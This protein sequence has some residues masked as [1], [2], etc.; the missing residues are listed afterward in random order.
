MRSF[1]LQNRG[2]KQDFGLQPPSPLFIPPI[3]AVAPPKKS[4]IGSHHVPLKTGVSAPV[5]VLYGP[6]DADGN[7]CYCQSWLLIDDPRNHFIFF[8]YHGLVEA[9]RV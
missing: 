1:K 5:S 8:F 9:W 7:S 4:L 6:V 3:P 2:E